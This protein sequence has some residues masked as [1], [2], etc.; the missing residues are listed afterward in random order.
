MASSCAAMRCWSATGARLRFFRARSLRLTAQ[1]MAELIEGY[2]FAFSEFPGPLPDRFD[3]LGRRRL[4]RQRGSQIPHGV[5][6]GIADV[7]PQRLPHE[8]GAGSMLL[9]PNAIEL[10]GHFCRERYRKHGRSTSHVVTQYYMLLR[11]NKSGRLS[12]GHE[13]GRY[14]LRISRLSGL[15]RKLLQALK[16]TGQLEMATICGIRARMMMWS[17]GFPFGGRI[18]HLPSWS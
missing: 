5:G 13:S 2:I 8:L 6:I 3:L 1:L 17:P 14:D 9:F 16:S 10:A 18:S 4:L 15:R 12:N 11:C 7:S